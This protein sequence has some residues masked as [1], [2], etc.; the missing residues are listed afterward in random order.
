M[1]S[2][3]LD[4]LTPILHDVVEEGTGKPARVSGVQIAGKT[5]TAEKFDDKSRE[6]SWVAG[7]WLDGYY[8]RLVIVMV[9][10]ATEEG[11]VKFEIAKAL[12][13]P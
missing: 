7:Y 6:I 5:G 1:K 8:K 10:V 11:P 2:G 12:L 3:T 13:K 9:D 4:T